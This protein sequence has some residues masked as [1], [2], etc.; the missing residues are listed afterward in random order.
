M[1]EKAKATVQASNVTYE[2]HTLGWKA[3]QDLCVSVT[4]EV[5]GQTVQAFLPNN[6]G[7]RD[8]AF[9]GK[10][11]PKSGETLNGAFTVQCKFSAKREKALR[12]ADLAD[13][14]TK[15]K[16]LVQKG[17]A[18]NYVLMTN[19]GLSA[20][21]EAEIRRPF[22]DSIGVASFTAFGGEW[23]SQKIRENP[24]LRMLVPRVYGLGDLS[25][26][27]DE[28]AYAQARE[29][30]SS[31]GDDLAKFVI[32]DAFNRSADALVKHG[33]V[34][35]LG[36]PASGK[37]TIAAALAVG[38]LDLWGCSTLKIRGA[39]D[40]VAHWN[41]HEP[42]Q[43]FW[44]DDAFG[45]TQFDAGA[46]TEWNRVFS[47]MESAIHRG[48][49]ILFTS[50]DY[51]YKAARRN[52]KEGAF[53]LIVE[54]QVVIDVEKLTKAEKEQILYNHVKLGSQ[55]PAYRRKLKPILPM[56][57]ANPH[58]LPEIARRLSNPVFTKELVLMPEVVTRFVEE[59][60]DFLLGVLRGL[61]NS[62][63]AAIALVFMRGGSL[64]S[65]V[66]PSLDE[67]RALEL[68]GGHLAG[69]R[70]AL[71]ALDGSLVK[72]VLEDGRYVW[73]FK[74]PTIRD[75]FASLVAEDPELL[76]IYLAGTPPEKLVHEISCGPSD[77]QGVKVIVPF[78]R[79][80]KVVQRLDGIAEKRQL[81]WFLTRRC[82]KDFL[83]A[84]IAQ[85]P[86]IFEQLRHW[87]AYLH[88]FTEV[89]LLG[90]LHECGLLPRDRTQGL[91]RG[92]L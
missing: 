42:R 83:S 8:G 38:A 12:F 25:Q 91:R 84:Y 22:V 18:T 32:T 90:R 54:S 43:F 66:T 5:L 47:H 65:P 79:Y 81:H 31:M 60:L 74:H 28:R 53:P 57:A 64:A 13:E 33:F 17:L 70:E 19:A 30:L 35:L 1:L 14:I 77:I 20:V 69:V 71:N 73:S 63:R 92:S 58:F 36:E 39:D 46:A 67:S 75:A 16:R 7:G 62:G 51:I 4:G 11:K 55:P 72:R 15:A 6:D 61:D 40:F 27:L 56:V 21:T 9:H 49:R 88:A 45:A 76:D 48:A 80:A 10:W 87:G 82:D 68:L 44:V 2:L 29:I 26:I 59:P 41:P 24:R 37:S 89:K 78:E 85:K 3:F 34:L 52:L 86:T 23:I 50:R